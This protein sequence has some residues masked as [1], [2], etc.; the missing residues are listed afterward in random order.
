[1]APAHRTRAVTEHNRGIHEDVTEDDFDI[2]I[3]GSDDPGRDHGSER[4]RLARTT[5]EQNE[6]TNLTNPTMEDPSVTSIVHLSQQTREL[7]EARAKTRHLAELAE[8]MEQ[9]AQFKERIARVTAAAKTPPR[10][11]YSTPVRTSREDSI[12]SDTEDGENNSTIEVPLGRRIT[13]AR[14]PTCPSTISKYSGKSIQEYTLWQAQLNNHFRQHPHYFVD[15]VTKITR[16]FEVLDTEMMLA[17]ESHF[18]KPGVPETYSEFTRFMQSLVDNPRVMYRE[19][20]I[21]WFRHMQK[22]GQSVMAYSLHLDQ[23]AKNMRIAPTEDIRKLRLTAGVL[24]ELQAEERRRAE[25]DPDC[26]YNTLLERYQS[27][28]SDLQ[29]SKKARPSSKPEHSRPEKAEKPAYKNKRKYSKTRDS[30]EKP[31]RAQE[32]SEHPS[33]KRKKDGKKPSVCE[34]CNML[35]HRKDTCWSL[36]GKPGE[37]KQLGRSEDRSKK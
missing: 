24:A 30:D 28:E 1:M 4:G 8:L 25:L 21:Q 27:I 17:W 14:C 23:I 22:P 35:G 20:G 10:S 7:E 5:R 18:T 29:S 11:T 26:T 37:Q 13:S 33:T 15:D 12:T 3:D 9:Q 2:D 6:P 16:G 34:H 31:Y 32:D 36:H 19:A